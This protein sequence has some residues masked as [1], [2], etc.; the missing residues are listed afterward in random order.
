M[1]THSH[2][3]PRSVKN[4]AVSLLPNMPSCCVQEPIYLYRSSVCRD[5]FCGSTSNK[6]RVTYFHMLFSAL[7][8]NSFTFRQHCELTPSVKYV[9]F[10]PGIVLLFQLTY[11]KERGIDLND[12][13]IS[14]ASTLCIYKRLQVKHP[15][16]FSKCLQ[17][18]VG[19]GS[20]YIF[21][22]QKCNINKV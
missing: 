18:N 15:R 11:F 5:Q 13:K 1:T 2:I 14:K 8:T 10:D 7:S 9:I 22:S 21:R 20:G 12:T 16:S 3:V 17:L 4:G 19:N 6:A